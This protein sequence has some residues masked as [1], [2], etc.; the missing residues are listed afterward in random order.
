MVLFFLDISSDF[1]SFKMFEDHEVDV[2]VL[3]PHVKHEPPCLSAQPSSA[4]A[5]D[6]DQAVTWILL[7]KQSEGIIILLILESRKDCS[8]K[9]TFSTFKKVSGVEGNS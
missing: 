2:E 5:S 7:S 8:A 1:N 9:L 6:V 3:S 4:M